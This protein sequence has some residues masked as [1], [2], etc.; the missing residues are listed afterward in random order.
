MDWTAREDLDQKYC[1]ISSQESFFSRFMDSE[2][3]HKWNG[4]WQPPVKCLNYFSYDYNQRPLTSKRLEA[5]HLRGDK[6]RLE[7]DLGAVKIIE[8]DVV[9]RQNLI[10][11]VE[12]KNN[13]DQD[14]Q[15]SLDLNVG[16]TAEDPQGKD[17]K[18][19]SR[20]DDLRQ[21]V[22]ARAQDRSILY[23]L[24][25][26]KGE[27]SWQQNEIYE[28]ETAQ[29]KSQSQ[30]SFSP[31]DYHV[32]CQVGAGKLKRLPFL[33]SFTP[34]QQD[35]R[36]PYDVALNSWFEQKFVKSGHLHKN[37]LDTSLDVI[38]N[39]YNWSNVNL[40]DLYF[41]SGHQKI[42]PGQR[43]FKRNKGQGKGV[44]FSGLPRSLFVSG[45]DLLWS[46]LGL[47]DMGEFKVVEEQLSLLA[48]MRR[49]EAEGRSRLPDKI[50]LAGEP[51]YRSA[52]IDPLFLLLLSY[53]QRYT[54][55]EFLTEAANKSLKAID[56]DQGLVK[57]SAQETWM[58]AV[59]RGQ[60]AVEIQSML[61]K[62][63]QVS[64]NL[65]LKGI[66]YYWDGETLAD[67]VENGRP[68]TTR[69]VNAI[70]PL[71][72]GLV[73]DRDKAIQ[74]LKSFNTSM[75]S[76]QGVNSLASKEDSYDPR[77]KYNGAVWNWLTLVA[78]AANLRYDRTKKAVSLINK[79]A[80]QFERDQIG[81][82]PS[83][84]G[85]ESGEVLADSNHSVASG[86]FFHTIDSYLLG[87]RPQLDR[88]RLLLAPK[89]PRGW[90]DVVRKDKRIGDNFLQLKLR[91]KST[92]NDIKL[93]LK[94]KRQPDFD[95][96]L[97]APGR[98]GQIKQAGR[99]KGSRLTF[100]PEKKTSLELIV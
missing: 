97:V 59:D 4:F 77:S 45:R 68:L 65:D 50:D 40:K 54:G 22:G 18:F 2:F 47:L 71:F 72:L 8:E 27:V 11:I 20:F 15:I 78:A 21:A 25:R 9:H 33:F 82:L 53:Y 57:H 91:R 30:K 90:K 83:Y 67:S 52:D 60:S 23:G 43:L 26:S 5:A 14:K 12:I 10:S 16:L 81:A 100:R 75:I 66:N 41:L 58:K 37:R 74:I 6:L 19:S 87:V 1:L 84:V 86:L 36:V 99:E 29:T 61:L 7:Y 94:F 51:Y 92:G 48:D 89:L 64:S 76:K 70:I 31:G 93:E 80:A 28:T 13:S 3:K 32:T 24:V 69:R 96:E 88:S 85:A 49:S 42:K 62:A 34:R 39:G 79:V 44:I 73:Q 56:I 17:L 63:N 38:N 46:L 55:Q 98:Q 95:L 35:V